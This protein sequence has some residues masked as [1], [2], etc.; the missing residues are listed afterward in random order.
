M[1]AR[2]GRLYA[3]T[4]ERIKAILRMVAYVLLIMQS[5]RAGIRG[6]SRKRCFT[7]AYSTQGELGARC[8]WL[9]V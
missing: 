6:H 8:V 1:L 7:Q 4:A 5:C 2:Y 3:V 9:Q